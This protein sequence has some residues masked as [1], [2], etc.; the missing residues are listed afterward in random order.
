MLT[1]H[2]IME[3]VAVIFYAYIRGRT[4]TN[5]GR[6]KDR[7]HQCLHALVSSSASECGLLRTP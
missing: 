2:V 1:E 5:D 4:D 7:P 6:L 3:A